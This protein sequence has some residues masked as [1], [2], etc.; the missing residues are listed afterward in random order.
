MRKA[1][2][3]MQIEKKQS[4]FHGNI[5]KISL[6]K[7]KNDVILPQRIQKEFMAMKKILLFFMV[8]PLVCFADDLTTNDGKVFRDYKIKKVSNM[9][10]HITHSHGVATIA[11][12]RLP[13]IL[14]RQFS[15][16]ERKFALQTKKMETARE[17]EMAL[18]EIATTGEYKILQIINNDTRN[19]LVYNMFLPQKSSIT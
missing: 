16:Q 3:K 12:S 18:K 13:P 17:E 9:G 8:G 19:R 7:L 6:D 10:I 1:E 15:Q 2:I 4:F 11:F 5:V 14:R